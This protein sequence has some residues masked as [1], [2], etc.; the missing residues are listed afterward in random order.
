MDL[1]TIKK[2]TQ[3]EKNLY[4]HIY[5]PQLVIEN[6]SQCDQQCIHCSHKEME[7][8]KKQMKRELWNKIVEEIGKNAPETEVWPTFYGEAL[9]MGPE[10]WDR[11]KYAEECGCKNLVLNSNGGLLQKQNHIDHILNSPLKRFIISIDGFKKETYEKIRFR[12][13]WER[14]YGGVEELLRRKRESKKIYP[15]IVC[16][17]SLMDEN[18]D[19]VEDYRAYWQSL[20]AEVKVRPK[21]EWTSSGSI[22]ASNLDHDTDFRIACPW[23]NNTMAIHQDGSVVACA[24]DWSGRVNVGNVENYTVKEMWDKLGIELR[25]A[26]REHKW[27][28]LPELCKG[29]VDWQTAGAEYETGINIEGARPFWY[30]EDTTSFKIEKKVIKLNST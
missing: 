16:Q 25:R 27:N 10:I 9:G 12:G 4:D 18:Q 29:C 1:L 19:E 6:T 20:G 11:I 14:T 7:R 15:L 17:F 26:H 28:E 3:I 13:K 22:V 30:N 23:A 2:L 24:V 21:L 5:P 8:P